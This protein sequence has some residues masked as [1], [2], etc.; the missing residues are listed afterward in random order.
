MVFIDVTGIIELLTAIAVIVIA[1][2]V[3]L[4]AT[5]NILL[6]KDEEKPKKIG[7][8]LRI[9]GCFVLIAAVAMLILLL[10]AAKIAR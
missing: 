2:G 10:I 9:I 7:S 8:V 6:E 4:I 3:A 5:G 1:I